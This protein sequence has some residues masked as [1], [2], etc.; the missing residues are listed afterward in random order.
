MVGKSKVDS[1]QKF[2][3]G[4]RAQYILRMSS[5]TKVSSERDF[6][7]GIRAG[8]IAELR[9]WVPDDNDLCHDFIDAQNHVLL[10]GMVNGHTHLAMTLYR[11]L[12]D[13]V[14]FQKWLF[15]RI[16]P[17][18]SRMVNSE[19]VRV[20]TE[21]A[22]LECIRF[23]VTTVNDMYYFTRVTADTL[24]RAGLRGLVGQPFASVPLP[25]DQLLGRDKAKLFEELHEKYCDHSRITAALAPHAP[26]TCNDQILREVV[27]LSDRF[28]APIHIH[29]S[30]TAHEVQDS[31]E[32]YQMSPVKRLFG[33]GILRKTTLAA[34]CVHLSD[35]D[36]GLMRSAGASIVYNPDSNLKLSSGI[37]PIARYRAEGIRVALGTDGA[38]SNNDLSIFGAMDLGTKLQKMVS[39][40][41]TAM[42]A[43]DALACATQEGADAL[44]LGG[45]IGSLE[46]G[47]EADLILVHLNHPHLQPV[48]DVQSLLVYS[49][50]GL[51]VD[52]VICQGKVLMKDGE[53]L[54]LDRERILSEAEALGLKVGHVAA[55]LPA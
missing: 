53:I 47:K 51:E 14:P 41:N 6:F 54:T 11:G 3:L 7:L 8:K 42:V 1:L 13:D 21:L 25:D 29:V 45:V 48:H 5:G 2:D 40:S 26:Y 18:E 10:P 35:E 33:L 15:D 4:I 9:P 27:A 23:G 36:I 55:S 17:L 50:S 22:A 28:D 44:G 30:E 19:F 24:D 20:G 49:A 38:A 16:L 37:A 39:G 46:I 32:L 12:E 43:R 52:T 34:H 31:L